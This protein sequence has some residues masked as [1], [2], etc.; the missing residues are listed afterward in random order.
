M[1]TTKKRRKKREAT[2]VIKRLENGRRI[3]GFD[4]KGNPA[5]SHEYVTGWGY[6]PDDLPVHK[7]PKI[8]V[9]ERPDPSAHQGSN[10]HG[11][12]K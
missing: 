10:G 5:S 2:T 8:E 3:I 6:H 12:E 11:G 9:E 4:G 1:A 7:R